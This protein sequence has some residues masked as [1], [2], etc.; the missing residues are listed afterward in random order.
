M[1]KW[2]ENKTTKQNK[3]KPIPSTMNHVIPYRGDSQGHLFEIEVEVEIEVEKKE[4]GAALFYS[5]SGINDKPQNF[6]CICNQT[7]KPEV[8]V[9]R[10]YNSCK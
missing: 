2:K 6:D 4:S 3:T 1:E 10:K 7:I 8:C 9:Q 5:L